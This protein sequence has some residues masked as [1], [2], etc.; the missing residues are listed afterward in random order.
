MKPKPDLLLQ[1]MFDAALALLERSQGNT[2][3]ARR[4]WMDVFETAERVDHNQ[5]LGEPDELDR[6]IDEQRQRFEQAEIA[7]QKFQV[8]K[9]GD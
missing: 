7:R 2:E 3:F 8:V 9:G 4:M 6:A 5:S 1:K